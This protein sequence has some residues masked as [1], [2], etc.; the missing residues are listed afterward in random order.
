MRTDYTSRSI[1]AD[2]EGN[3]SGFM[4][5]RHLF[6]VKSRVVVAPGVPAR[7]YKSKVPLTE[8][9]F[10]SAWTKMSEVDGDEGRP[11]AILPTVLM[12]P[13]SLAFI[14]RKLINSA[15]VNGGN[16]N[17]LLSMVDVVVNPYL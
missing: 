13:N 8:A 17:H 5:D 12:V 6:G 7:I 2:A 1:K 16:S 4:T 14:A 11:L 15:L 10:E 3:V 9:S